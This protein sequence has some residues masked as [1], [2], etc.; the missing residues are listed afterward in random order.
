MNTNIASTFYMICC[1]QDHASCYYTNGVG[2]I[3]IPFKNAKSVEL[4][5]ITF[6]GNNKFTRNLFPFFLK[7]Q[8]HI[9][10]YIRW[11]IKQRSVKVFLQRQ[12]IGV[13]R[14]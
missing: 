12:L 1:K 2:C 8:K 4:Q 14:I 11:I 9:H 7:F 13:Q 6:Y 3:H 5:K 10:R